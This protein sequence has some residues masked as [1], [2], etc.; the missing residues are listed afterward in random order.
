M[1]NRLRLPFHLECPACGERDRWWLQ[2]R[3]GTLT[4]ADY[5]LGHRVNWLRRGLK[6]GRPGLGRVLI[7]GTL[8]ECPHCRADLGPAHEIWI[9]EVRD[10][11]FA[12]VVEDTSGQGYWQEFWRVA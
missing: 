5:E 1:Y 10:D 11:V 12:T 9:I 2:F 7:Q 4:L 6:E 8:E 3:F